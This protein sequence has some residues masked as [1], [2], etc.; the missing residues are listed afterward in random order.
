M[1]WIT[2]ATLIARYGIPFVEK[3][4]S[5]AQNKAPVTPQEWQALTVLIQTPGE[6]L[7]PKRPGA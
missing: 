2:I 5:N 4:M 1:D 6:V 3:L 7:I